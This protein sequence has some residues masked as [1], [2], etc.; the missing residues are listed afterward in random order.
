MSTQHTLTENTIS[1]EEFH[2]NPMLGVV[3]QPDSD[4]QKMLV[5]YVGTK[6]DKE[7][8]TVHMIAEIIASEFPEFAWSYAEENYLRGYQQ[9]LDDAYQTAT[10]ETPATIEE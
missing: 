1:E 4:L 8:V 6:F 2:H 10:K 9:G 5:D 3:V 7:D